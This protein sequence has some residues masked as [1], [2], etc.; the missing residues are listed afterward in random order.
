MIPESEKEH[1]HRC[2]HKENPGR[3]LLQERCSLKGVVEKRM[4]AE[5]SALV[6]GGGGGKVSL[7]PHC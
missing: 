7:T 3:P 6:G 4:T 2:K 5:P 1:I